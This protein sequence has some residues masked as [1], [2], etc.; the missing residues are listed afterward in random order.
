MH[1]AWHSDAVQVSV[2]SLEVHHHVITRTL[3]YGYFRG[4]LFQDTADSAASFF[5]LKESKWNGPPFN[6]LLGLNTSRNIRDTGYGPKEIIQNFG[7][8]SSKLKRA[9]TRNVSCKNSLRWL[10]RII[11]SDE[12]SKSSFHKLYWRS[13][14]VSLETY[15]FI[16]LLIKG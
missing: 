13:T 8:K 5:L 15:P 12:N 9:N 14:I 3:A 6:F 4:V 2:R 11:N 1:T 16:Y 7:G 10:I